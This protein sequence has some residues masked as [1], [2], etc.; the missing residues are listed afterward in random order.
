MVIDALS[1]LDHDPLGDGERPWCGW[2][3]GRYQ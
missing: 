3:V 1:E 2:L